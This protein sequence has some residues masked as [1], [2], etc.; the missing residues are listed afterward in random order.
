MLGHHVYCPVGGGAC[1]LS[2]P[3]VRVVQ[4]RK[5]VWEAKDHYLGLCINPLVSWLNLRV[6]E[7]KL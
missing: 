1:H 4:M 2:F 6:C 3:C 5:L 7:G